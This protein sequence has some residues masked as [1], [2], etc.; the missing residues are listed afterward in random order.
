MR[1]LPV[2]AAI[3]LVAASLALGTI[4]GT[5]T[6]AASPQA[7]R[8]TNAQKVAAAAANNLG[9]STSLAK[10]LQYWLKAYYGYTG[11]LDGRLGTG[12]WKALQRWLRNYSY[13]GPIDGVVGTKTIK[14]LQRYLRDYEGYTGPIDGIAGAGTKAAFRRFA[15]WTY[16]E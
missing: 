7:P 14:A 1:T 13:T 12:S 15:E 3:G 16:V 5:G 4:A 11:A 2:K 9:L 10:E 6:A 8:S